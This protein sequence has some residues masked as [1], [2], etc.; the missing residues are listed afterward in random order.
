MK[1]FTKMLALGMA[2]ALTFGMTV[3]AKWSPSTDAEGAL[4]VASGDLEKIDSWEMAAEEKTEVAGKALD[5]A[6][7]MLNGSSVC[8][9]VKKMSVRVM[10]VFDLSVYQ[11]L[12]VT[13]SAAENNTRALW[14]DCSAAS[15]GHTWGYAMIRFDKEWTISGQE[16]IKMNRAAEGKYV[17]HLDQRNKLESAYYVVVKWTADVAGN[18]LHLDREGGDAYEQ[19]FAIMD[20][21]TSL[22]TRLNGDL[23]IEIARREGLANG[24]AATNGWNSLIVNEKCNL[25]ADLPKLGE[26]EKYALVSCRY[27][28]GDKNDIGT[29]THRVN[30]SDDV[31]TY[32]VMEDTG[33]KSGTGDNL[34]YKAKNVEKGEQFFM[35]VKL[36]GEGGNPNPPVVT[37]PNPGTSAGS[38]GQTSGGAGQTTGGAVSPKT[39][40]MLPVA[41]ILAAICLAGAAVCAKKA[42]TN[43]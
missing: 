5:V 21:A 11:G 38:D 35:V 10:E 37:D 19:Y 31:P 28:Y 8:D 4:E 26:G 1:R 24:V 33:V 15:Y 23:G 39:G 43:A 29:N 9:G 40:E 32:Y 6:P 30:L 20:D 17:A 12:D 22:S 18:R 16:L 42:R 41:V 13:F 3:S 36:Y 7:G 25:K 2:M 34:F 27:I 14:Y